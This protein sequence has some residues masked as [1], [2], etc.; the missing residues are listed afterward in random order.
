VAIQCREE[1]K[2]IW[3]QATRMAYL[4]SLNLNLQSK[5]MIISN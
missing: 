4:I 2:N 3:L 5:S 1:A